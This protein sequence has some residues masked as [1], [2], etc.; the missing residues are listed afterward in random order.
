MFNS[1]YGMIKNHSRAGLSHNGTDA[2]AHL[3]TVAMH[4]ASL[5]GGLLLSEFAVTQAV[6]GVSE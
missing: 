5:A 2:G 3:G 6:Y 1:G 4:G